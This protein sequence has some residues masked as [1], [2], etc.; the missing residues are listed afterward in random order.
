[1]FGQFHIIELPRFDGP[2]QSISRAKKNRL[3]MNLIMKMGGILFRFD[4]LRLL[5]FP[6]H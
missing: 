3:I 2:E 6:E 5:A 4:F 1:V